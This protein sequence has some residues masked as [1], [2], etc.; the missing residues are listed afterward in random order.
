MAR[1]APTR[2]DQR[3]RYVDD[4]WVEASDDLR[5][6]QLTSD[7]LEHNTSSMGHQHM[8][9]RRERIFGYRITMTATLSRLRPLGHVLRSGLAARLALLPLLRLSQSGG[10]LD[11]GPAL[12]QL[13][14]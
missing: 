10:A 12:T 9:W 13:L 4:P 6:G 8:A 1:P 11:G 3:G 5:F 7:L 2:P 14:E